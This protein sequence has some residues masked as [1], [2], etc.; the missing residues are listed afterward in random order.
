MQCLSLFGQ[1]PRT[2]SLQ[3]GHDFW[4]FKE[5]A[6]EGVIA[7]AQTSDGFL[8]LG[9]SAGLF[10]FDGIRFDL[11]H[12]RFG[13]PLL[14]TNIFALF[15]PR[16]GGLWIG[17]AFGGFSFLKDGEVTNCSAETASATGSVWNFAQDKDGIVWATTTSG[18]W[19]FDHSR[20]QHVGRETSIP[21]APFQEVRFDREGTLWALTG[22]GHP[23]GETQLIYLHRGN[24][25]FE[26]A[27]NVAVAGF[28]LDAD[29]YV[30]TSP[31]RRAFF[32]DASANAA[33]R[34]AAYPLLRKGSHQIVDRAGSVWIVPEEPVTW[35]LPASGQRISDVLA[36]ASPGNAETYDLNPYRLAK[37]VD[38][39]GNIWFGDAK[40]IHR[41]FYSPLKKQALPNPAAGSIYSTVTPDDDGAVWIAAGDFNK[42]SD[43][44]WSSIGRMKLRKAPGSLTGFAYRASD[45][46]IWFGG[47]GGLWHLVKGNFLRVDLPKEMADQAMFLQTITQDHSGG[48][49]VSFGR[50][51]LYRLANGVWVSCGGRDDLP[52]TGVVIEFTDSLGRV[53]FGYTKNTLAV[54]EGNG[55]QVFGLN[56]GLRVGNVTAIYGR[57]S[58]IWI[59]G[60]FGLQQFNHGR[61]T[62]IRATNEEWLRGISGIAETENGDLWLNGLGGIFHVRRSELS[63]ALENS[64]YQVKGEHFGRRDG[65]PGPAF[66]LRPLNTAVEGTDGRIWFTENR[67]VVWLDPSKTENKLPAPPI[68]I[69]SI[70]ADDRNYQLAPSVQ[71]PPHTSSVQINYAAVSLSNPETIRFRYNLQEADKG[72]QHVSAAE[73]VSYRNLSPG[74]YHFIVNATDT[75]GVWSDAVATKEFTILPAF[76]QTRWFIALCFVATLAFLCMLYMLRLRQ[77]G[78]QFE[79]RL[80]ERVDERT[81]IARDL[82][83][84]LLQSFQGLVLRFQTASNLLGPHPSE[85][86]QT[87]DGAIDQAAEAITEAR[88]AVEQLRSST[89]VSN[90]L[91]RAI[92][93]LGESLAS[94][95]SRAQSPAFHVAVEGTRRELHPISRDEVYRIASEA[96]RNA[97]RYSQSHRIE[98]EVHYDKR[99]LRLRIRDDG[100]GIDARHLGGAEQSRHFGLRGMRERAQRLG[101]ELTIWT[102]VGSGTELELVVPSSCVYLTS[103]VARASLFGKIRSRI[104]L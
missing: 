68:T 71:F 27:G 81:R 51:G 19:R 69:Q 103:A 37:L 1:I 20:W 97:F 21:S 39:E 17:Y 98:V 55:V 48:M 64:S 6:P 92:T 78:V 15:A 80:E 74:L 18:L 70:S 10:R 14:S 43:I 76:Y 24:R 40:G 60:E 85:A 28:T 26:V 88:D 62:D 50:Q 56:D 100:V 58:E 45:K 53:W 104:N 23:S 4:G 101:A 86:K 7:L 65:V 46:T 34:P 90:D 72:W 16:S 61:F 73:P 87:L 95:E 22:T 41:F 31:E 30:V 52:K 79:V 36:Q 11:F 32:N 59:G 54:L 99:E 29:G 93:S 2:A 49:W 57:G 35:R 94:D 89:A 5:G 13:D 38:R 44:I 66:Q 77:L 47:A 9:S 91:V 25:Q 8:W 33:D 3:V 63:E 83:D 75:N 82:H 67:G 102:E 12:F 84:T 42:P 96:L